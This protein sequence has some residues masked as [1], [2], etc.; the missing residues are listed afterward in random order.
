ML[1]EVIKVIPPEQAETRYESEPSV[2][3]NIP[4]VVAQRSVSRLLIEQV[5]NL[6]YGE[7]P[8]LVAAGRL[9]WRVP[10]Y[11]GSPVIG[12]VGQ[13]GT[14]DVDAQTGEILF[15]QPTL[16]ELVELGDAM[17]ERATSATA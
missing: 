15:D 11:L 1:F 4:S 16:A 13:V 12:V 3:V 2:K 10:V 5:G 6:L 17:A 8:S 7:K 9:L 14:L